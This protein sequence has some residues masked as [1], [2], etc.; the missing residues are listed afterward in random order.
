M[1]LILMRYQQ[2]LTLSREY[3]K[4]CMKLSILAHDI[5]LEK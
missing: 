4:C 2:F 5:Y 3:K 1:N